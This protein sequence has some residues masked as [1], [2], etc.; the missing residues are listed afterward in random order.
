MQVVLLAEALSM[1][2]WKHLDLEAENNCG[3]VDV[4]KKPTKPVDMWNFC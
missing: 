4:Q 2:S 3:V 1:G